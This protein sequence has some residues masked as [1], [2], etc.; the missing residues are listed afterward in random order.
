[1]QGV[2]K[3]EVMRF[4]NNLEL[5]LT[6]CKFEHQTISCMNKTEFSTVHESEIILLL[7]K[8]GSVSLQSL[9][10]KEAITWRQCALLLN[11]QTINY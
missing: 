1:M 3:N 10:E 7:S 6:K 5:E 11:N 2:N 8:E 9:H 4:F